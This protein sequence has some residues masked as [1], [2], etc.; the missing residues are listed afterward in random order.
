M[1]NRYVFCSALFCYVVERQALYVD[2]KE[3]KEAGLWLAQRSTASGV[4][5]TAVGIDTHVYNQNISQSRE[6]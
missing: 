1:L 2:G 5:G 4:T 3:R 6:S